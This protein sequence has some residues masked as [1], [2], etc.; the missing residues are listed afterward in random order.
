MIEFLLMGAQAAGAITDIIGKSQAYKTEK[1]AIGIEQEQIKARMDQERLV[2]Q[3]Q[4]LADLRNLEQTLASQRAFAAARGVNPGQGSALMQMQRSITEFRND[5]IARNLSQMFLTQQRSTQ[6]RAKDL[7]R[8]SARDKFRIGL[9]K[10]A[11]ENISTMGS[12]GGL[13]SLTLN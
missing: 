10:T 7:E 9:F 4:S 12:S 6:L 1:L 2:F 5:E 11:F 13:G 8:K 3:E